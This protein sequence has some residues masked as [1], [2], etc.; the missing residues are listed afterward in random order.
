MTATRTRRLHPGNYIGGHS[1]ID[2]STRRVVVAELREL[3]ASL[4]PESGEDGT[5]Y[6]SGVRGAQAV[7]LA[8][9]DEIED[10][11]AWRWDCGPRLSEPHVP[12]CACPKPDA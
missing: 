3:A 1:G 4:T 7:L 5:D 12:G 8:R 10:A 11:G 9:A 2:G 6:A